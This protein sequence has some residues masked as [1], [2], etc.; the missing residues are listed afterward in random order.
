MGTGLEGMVARVGCS[1]RDFMRKVNK[2]LLL[3]V[4]SS[5]DARRRAT[6]YLLPIDAKKKY[7]G[8]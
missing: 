3:W 5:S 8:T 1:Q 4:G 2:L 7:S 6:E